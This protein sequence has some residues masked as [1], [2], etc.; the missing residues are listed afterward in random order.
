M[1]KYI[2]NIHHSFHTL[3]DYTAINVDRANSINYQPL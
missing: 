1:T 2:G 3:V